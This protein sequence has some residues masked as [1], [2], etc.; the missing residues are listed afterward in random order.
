MEGVGMPTLP[1]TLQ[2]SGSLQQPMQPSIVRVHSFVAK[3]Q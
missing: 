3:Q 1:R 2:E